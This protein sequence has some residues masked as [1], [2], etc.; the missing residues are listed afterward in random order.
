MY[1]TSAQKMR[2]V[3]ERKCEEYFNS[4]DEPYNSADQQITLGQNYITS[5]LTHYKK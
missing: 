2:V 1:K 5:V 3:I 4:K